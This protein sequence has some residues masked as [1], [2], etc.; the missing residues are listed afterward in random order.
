MM[1]GAASSGGV[2]HRDG[3]GR[4]DRAEEHGG[5]GRH[6]HQGVHDQGGPVDEHGPAGEGDGDDRTTETATSTFSRGHTVGEL[7]G[8]RGDDGGGEHPDEGHDTHLGGAA[9]A[10]RVDREDARCGPLGRPGREG[11]RLCPPKV[12]VA[13]VRRERAGGRTQPR[14]LRS[15]ATLRR[16]RRRV[17][18][19][20]ARR[21]PDGP[22]GR[23]GQPAGGAGSRSRAALSPAS[24]ASSCMRPGVEVR[25]TDRVAGVRAR[26]GLLGHRLEPDMTAACWSTTSRRCTR[27]GAGHDVAHRLRLVEH[28]LD[29]AAAHPG[30]ADPARAPR[31]PSPR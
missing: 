26:L 1:F 24:R 31:R 11:R 9:P 12:G 5:N 19:R 3:A 22:A 10:V 13:P 8:Q 18:T 20:A 29:L 4:N 15:R 2:S 23:T 6:R 21:L 27:V 28:D 17:A 25:V 7:G 14:R 30:L 16:H